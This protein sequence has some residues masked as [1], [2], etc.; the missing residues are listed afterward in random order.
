MG[1]IY[2]LHNVAFKIMHL[3]INFSGLNSYH[4]LYISRKKRYFSDFFRQIA[5]VVHFVFLL[6]YTTTILRSG[7]GGGAFCLCKMYINWRFF[8][9][10]P[11]GGAR[12]LRNSSRFWRPVPPLTLTGKAPLS[13]SEQPNPHIRLFS[14]IRGPC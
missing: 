8:C 4:M 12:E 14:P 10:G 13:L 3:K 5:V 2:R 6:N 11:R 9:V 1:C 7:K